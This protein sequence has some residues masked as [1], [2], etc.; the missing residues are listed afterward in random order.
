MPQQVLQRA[1][2][3]HPAGQHHVVQR[4]GL[5]Q[6]RQAPQ[7]R[8]HGG[9]V[10][11]GPAVHLD[12]QP[13]VAV[14]QVLDVLH[15]FEAAGAHDLLDPP[16]H[17][18]RTHQP[19]QLQ[20]ADG[21]PAGAH[22]DDLG[23]GPD[24]DRAPPPGVGLGQPVVQHHPA[25]GE[26]RPAQHRH[27]VPGGDPGV[28]HLQAHRLGH[29]AQV[30]RRHVRGHAHGDPAGAVHQQVRQP[31]GQ[32]QRLGGLTVVAG[33]EVHR[34]LVQLVEH[35]HGRRR[36]PALGVPGGRRRV[37]EGAEVALRVHQ[38]HAPAEVLAHAHQGVVDGGVAVGVVVAHRVADHPGALAVRRVG[39]QPHAQHR[40]QDPALH[41][42][43]AVAHVGNRPG[44]D[45]RQRVGQERLRNLLD[46][47]CVDDLAGERRAG[48]RPLGLSRAH[49]WVLTSTVSCRRGAGGPW[50]RL[51]PMR[52]GS[53]SM[54]IS[55]PVQAPAG[56]TRGRCRSKCRFIRPRG[57]CYIVEAQE[58][59]KNIIRSRR[60][61]L[62][63]AVS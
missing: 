23:P 6:G 16:H 50:S 30:V 44:R 1:G 8:Q 45:H 54:P 20:D 13:G 60:T 18:L 62:S 36:Q 38:R 57:I 51:G 55:A 3:R 49:G 4:E 29:L 42:L 19:R 2:H 10:G 41:R 31:R 56:D 11:A 37:V 22:L 39:P 24:P 48:R 9:G 15:A 58:K 59:Y 47:G 32:A 63:C 61:F 46:D 53:A 52:P 5:L 43:E 21:L 14:R 33:P 27:E 34:V 17:L 12:A 35:L 40:V 25:G 26:V 7:L 28:G